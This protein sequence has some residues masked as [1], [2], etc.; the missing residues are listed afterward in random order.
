MAD[1]TCF[2]CKEK[3]PLKSFGKRKAS[4]DGLQYQCRECISQ[5][6]RNGNRPSRQPEYRAKYFQ[7]KEKGSE[8]YLKNTRRA[9]L[10]K[11]YGI[12]PEIYEKMRSQQ[13]GKCGMCGK[14]PKK[15]LAVDHDHST[16]KIRGLLCFKCNTFI[17][18]IETSRDIVEEATIYLEKYCE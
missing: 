9:H 17:G 14:I 1:K 8:S 2:L 3:K 4:P 12:T 13:K 11:M 7:E 18:Y 5:Y 6:E 10:K 15:R 16:D